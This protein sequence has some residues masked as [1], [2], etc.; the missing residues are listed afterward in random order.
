ME[1]TNLCKI[2]N[3]LIYRL[4]FKQCCTSEK[5]WEW[6]YTTAGGADWLESVIKQNIDSK[7]VNSTLQLFK[8]FIKKNIQSAP[9]VV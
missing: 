3:L 9:S 8:N 7:F 5:D 6:I 4:L 1:R 2:S